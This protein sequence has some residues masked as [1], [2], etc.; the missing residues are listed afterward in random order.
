MWTRTTGESSLV[1]DA[2][3]FGKRI[4]AA[5]LMLGVSVLLGWFE[6]RGPAPL[7]IDAPT[8]QPSAARMRATLVELLG[9]PP[10]KHTTGTASG[11]AFL[12]RLEKKLRGYEV[13]MRRIEIPWDPQRQDRHPG[14]RVDLLPPGTVLKNLWVTVEGSDPSLAPILI[15]THHDSCRWGP[16]A[17]DAGSAVVTLVE[18]IRH[19]STSRPVRTTHYLFTDGEE[20]GLLGAYA[21]VA[22]ESLPFPRPAF[23]LN[24][25]ARGTRGGI[26]M[27]ETHVNNS[28]W[29]STIIDDLARPKIT[30]SLAVTIYRSLPNAT[31][32]NAWHGKLGLSGFNY[33]VIGG[34]HRYHRPEDTPQNLSDRTLQHM[35]A[36]LFSMHRAIDRL[37]GPTTR[38]LNASTEDPAHGNAVFFDLYGWTVVHFGEGIQRVIAIVAAALMG[39]VCLRG[40]SLGRVRRLPRHALV[41]LLSIAAGLLVGVVIQLGLRTTPFSVLKYTPIDLQAGVVTI[42]AS[43]LVVTAL[44]ERFTKRIESDEAE[45]VSD[46]I[47]WVTA[48]LGTVLAMALPG[49]AYL[50]VLPSFTYALVRIVSPQATLAA[51]SGW[52]AAVILAGPLVMLLVQALGPWRQPVY[53]ALASLLAVLAMT[54]WAAQKKA[55]PIPKNRPRLARG[56]A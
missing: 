34:A 24:F 16:G 36:Q 31:D 26:A 46:W 35:G 17:G 30:S 13:P 43:F 15:A 39:V 55:R 28:G 3:N 37:D 48:A 5:T 53:A 18:H 2:S 54:A 10:Q 11:E 22:Q 42:A 20:F 51:W 47:W 1:G 45:V 52:A 19:L 14:G 44:L 9:D 56:D 8:D 6:Y 21:I 29:V 33:A 23:V 49:G 40:R 4:V 12:Q 7:G 27:F 38:R 25:D 32:F 41:V 50:L